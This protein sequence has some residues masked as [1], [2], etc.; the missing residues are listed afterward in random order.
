MDPIR[1]SLSIEYAFL[2]EACL[3]SFCCLMRTDFNFA[4]A[5]ICYYLWHSYRDKDEMKEHVARQ[6][7]GLNL[8][9]II[10]DLI[11]LCIMGSVWGQEPVSGWDGM[12]TM[13]SFTIFFSS[14]NLIIKVGVVGML[15]FLHK[16]S[17]QFRPNN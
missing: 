4:F 16:D 15:Y 10:V 2:L 13:H 9:L 3:A 7:F 11:W 14:L 6:L 8:F 1:M 5:L 17:F 12:E